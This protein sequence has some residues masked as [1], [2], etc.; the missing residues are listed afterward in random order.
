MGLPKITK[1]RKI[2]STLLTFWIP[3]KK[4]RR[5]LRGIFMIGL[6]NYLHI[7]KQDKIYKFKNTLSIGAIMK[8]EG[9]YLKEWLDFHILVGV[10]KFYLYDNGSTDNTVDILAPYIERGV[11]EYTYYP[12]NFRQQ[13]AYLDI[14]EKHSGD[15][16]WLAL[17]DLDEFIVP[18]QHKTI[19]EFLYTLPLNFAQLVIAWIIYGSSG[20][21]TK[22]DGLLIENYTCHAKN[23]WGIKSIINP[24]LVTTIT[25]PHANLVAGSTIDENG[26]MLGRIN[27]SDSPV[28]SNFI[29]CNHYITKSMEECIARKTRALGWGGEKNVETAKEFFNNNDRN[30]VRDNV[31]NRFV[32]QLKDEK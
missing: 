4:Y 10:E 2:I 20:H 7:I 32:K 16:R 24:R 19:P 26:K 13:S 5:A 9:P 18:V 1:T 17:I 31:M 8:D 12:G 27:Q 15:T 14:I 21:K 28:S 6:F 22:P 23:S 30:D 3:I 11:V 25:N 29:R